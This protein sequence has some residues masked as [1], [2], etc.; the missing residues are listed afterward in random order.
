LRWTVL[1]P[2]KGLPQAKSRL[3]E[4]TRS[5]ADHAQLVQAIRADTLRAVGN[6]QGVARVVLIT[7]RAAADG[8]P[9]N[10][11]MLVQTRP[12]LNEAIEQGAG[13]AAGRWPTDGI[14]ALVGDL[15][16]LTAAE[17]DDALN[18]AAGY[19]RSFVPDSEGIGTS[20]LAAVPG[21]ALRPRFGTDSA[22]RHSSDAD[23]LDA[24]PG[25]R[26]DV[27]TPGDLN[28]ARALGLG[29]ATEAVLAVVACL[30]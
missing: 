28:A 16:A 18:L 7:D 6:A 4:A 13:Y 26:Q 24:G 23:R 30:H 2:V 21:V 27:D 10:D 15:P 12:G 3:A 8:S 5:D 20:M 14:A 11:L 19:R 25:L 17:L 9:A 29:P 22:A 1:V